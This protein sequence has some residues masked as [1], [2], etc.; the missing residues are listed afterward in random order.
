[1]DQD[2][3]AIVASILRSKKYRDTHEGTIRELARIEWGRHKTQRQVEQAVRE[4]LHGIVAAYIGDPDYDA[5]EADLTAAF[6][7]DDPQA[8]RQACARVLNSHVSTRER[9]LIAGRFYEAIFAITGKPAALLDLACGLNPLTFPWMGLP[10]TLAYYA[11]DIHVRRVAL[12]NTY[13]RLQGLRPLARVQ[14]VAFDPPAE[15]ADVALVLKELPRFE[16]NYEGRGMALLAGLN[17][18]YL[19]VSFP[20]VSV[21]GG[22]SLTDHYRRSF[23]EMIAGTGWRTTEIAFESELVFCCESANERIANSESAA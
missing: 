20:T 17:V 18:R 22:R 8:V 19:V 6:R 4:R 7:S 3:E 21:H 10:P 11:Y 14:D 16:R 1:M 15:P 12:L 9:L 23:A 13:F 5:A 2:V